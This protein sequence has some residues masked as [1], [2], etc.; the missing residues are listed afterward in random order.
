MTS[1][2]ERPRPRPRSDR[3]DTIHEM[4]CRYEEARAEN[5]GGGGGGSQHESRINAFDPQTWTREYQELERCLERL[6]WLAAHGRPMI[7]K[8]VSSSTAWWHLRHRYLETH[9]VRR[10]V[11]LKKTHSG[12]RTLARLRHNEEVLARQTILN[13]RKSFVLLRVWDP[14]VEPTYVGAA[15]RW[16]AREFKGTPAVYSETAA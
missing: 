11:H 3:V 8:N 13:G 15:L 2:L 7:E 10:E 16:I 1:L 14:R 12:D 9:T 6:R 4:L 5:G